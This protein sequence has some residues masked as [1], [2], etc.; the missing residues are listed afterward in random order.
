M[1]LAHWANLSMTRTRR[2]VSRSNLLNATLTL[3]TPRRQISLPTYTIPIIGSLIYRICRISSGHNL[4]FLAPLLRSCWTLELPRRKTAGLLGL[5]VG[6]KVT[7]RTSSGLSAVCPFFPRSFCPDPSPQGRPRFYPPVQPSPR[8]NNTSARL[9]NIA[10]M[11]AVDA[12]QSG[13]HR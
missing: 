13:P 9:T 10:G 11:L 8:Y 3:G 4:L 12:H 2:S 1:S 7:A 5:N 6:F